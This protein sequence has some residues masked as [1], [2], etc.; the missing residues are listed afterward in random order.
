MGRYYDSYDIEEAYQQAV[1]DMA[2]SDM[3]K[4][5]QGGK[6]RCLYRTATTKAENAAD[7]TCLLES[8]IYPAFYQRQDQ[9]RTGRK[10][11]T[12]R[13]QSNLNDKNS[14]REFVRVAVANFGRGDYYATYGWDD[15][16]MPA[17]TEEAERDVR[18]F[19]KRLNYHRKR[20][21][22]GN[23]RYMYILAVDE[24]T[25]PHVHILLQ[26]D[27]MDRDEVENLWIKCS[28]KT[29][30]RIAPDEN[31]L[32]TGLATYIARNPRGT[33]RWRCSKGLVRPKPTKSY[34]KFRRRRVERMVR[35]HDTL[36]RERENAYPGY[37]VLDAEVKDTG[38]K[39]AFYIYARMARREAAPKKGGKRKRE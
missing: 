3:E 34:T 29:T 4:L 35:D 27:G 28:R 1:E 38:V 26:A 14:R 11:P 24:Y 22:L 21:G 7:G 2:E 20:K 8:Q 16:H 31:Y 12:R 37:R 19:F 32:I 25:R 17:S 5:L 30:R 33:K 9:P 18:N 39:A 23:A 13:S 6:V 10:R 15:E 36:G